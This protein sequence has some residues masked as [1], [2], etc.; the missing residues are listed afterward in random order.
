[1]KKVT[2]VVALLGVLTVG[3]ADDVSIDSEI[4][5]IQSA[6]AQERVQLMNQFKQKL[7]LMNQA[8]RSEAISRLQVKTQTRTQTQAQT[9]ERVQEMRMNNERSMTQMNNAN[10]QEAAKQFMKGR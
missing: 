8:D 9:R 3:F 1:V 5:A 10:Q 7:S 6:P 2:I 4:A